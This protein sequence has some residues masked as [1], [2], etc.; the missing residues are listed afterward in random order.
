[1]KNLWRRRRGSPKISRN[2][3]PGVA[4]GLVRLRCSYTSHRRDLFV[5]FDFAGIEAGGRLVIRRRVGHT[6]LFVWPSE[7]VLSSSAMPANPTSYLLA[8]GNLQESGALSGGK[9]GLNYGSSKWTDANRSIAL[10]VPTLLIAIKITR[11]PAGGDLTRLTKN[12]DVA[13]RSERT[14]WNQKRHG[15][16][17]GQE[18]HGKYGAF[19]SFLERSEGKRKKKKVAS[20]G[21]SGR[22]GRTAPRFHTK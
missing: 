12:M 9:V 16:R 2:Y 4:G 21:N 18:R 11:L 17:R 19:L 6:G 7:G 14:V 8:G 13:R 20:I 3:Q 22:A 10:A 15:R 1:M 5:K